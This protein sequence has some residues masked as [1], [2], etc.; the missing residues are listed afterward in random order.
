MRR[1]HH[2][3]T[4]GHCLQFVHEDGTLLLEGL[5]DVLVVDD[6]LA[7]VH[8][9]AVGFQRAFNRDDSAVDTRAVT[10]RCGEDH[11]FGTVVN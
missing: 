3:R 10:A 2:P 11:S 8:G 9:C 7:D 4:L 6:L 5:H 1:E